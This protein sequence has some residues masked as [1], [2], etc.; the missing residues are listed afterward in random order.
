MRKIILLSICLQAFWTTGFSQSPPFKDADVGIRDQYTNLVVH[1]EASKNPWP[2]TLW[3]YAMTPTKFSPAVISNLMAVTGYTKKDEKDYGTNGMIF[4][5]PEKSG[6]MRISFTEGEI[7][8]WTTLNYGPTNLAQ[9]VPTTN[10]L[11]HLTT[12]F[13]SKIGIRL[14]ELAKD[15]SG[16]PKIYF[17]EASTEYFVN[18]TTITNIQYRMV[19]FNR[20][21]LLYTSDAAD[22]LLC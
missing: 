6:N 12:N 13:L 21:C 9:G 22:D 8:Y 17:P 2:K 11:F 1:W 15:K 7:E 14:S 18:N 19:R 10:Q 5:S 4:V 20:A 3:V 16:Q